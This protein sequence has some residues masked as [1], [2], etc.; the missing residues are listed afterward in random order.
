MEKKEL[1]ISLI[2]PAYNE[3]RYIGE[4]LEYVVKNCNEKIFEIIVVDNAS[5]DKTA[6][7]AKKYKD[8]KVITEN[9]KGLTK[10]R[11]RGFLESKGNIIANI[12]ADTRMPKGWTEKI[13]E[14][15]K[16]NK[17]L[18]CLSGPYIYYDISP[19]KTFLVKLYWLISIPIYRLVGYMIVGGNF[20]IKRNILEKMNGFDTNIEFFGEDTNIARRA[21]KFGQVKFN[22][23]LCMYTSGRRLNETGF[24]KTAY[25]Y[26]IE[27]FSQIIRHKSVRQKYTDIR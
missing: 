23:D 8:V 21:S 24:L 6:E 22:Y 16:N 10:A 20:A 7:I 12:D 27:Y 3:E 5:T 13:I 4:C 1:T 14:E 19:W 9:S 2:I 15:F 17:E 25:I 11:Q 26:V 18:A